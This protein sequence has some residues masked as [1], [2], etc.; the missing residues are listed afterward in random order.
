MRSGGGMGKLKTRV[1]TSREAGGYCALPW[2]VLDSPAYQALS[3]PARAL[4]LE[5]ARQY[6]RDNNG[7]LL[8]SVRHLLTRGWNSADTITRAKNELLKSK[9]I[10]RTVH[11]HRPNTASWYALTWYT[12]DKI[13][14]Y[15]EGA[16]EGFRRGMYRTGLLPTHDA[17]AADPKKPTENKTLYRQTVQGG[18]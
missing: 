7:R 4:L 11:G 3:H 14:G 15:D 18:A 1:D 8:L 10:Y 6:V 16:A 17:G 5:L 9:L 12:L 2:S 13:P